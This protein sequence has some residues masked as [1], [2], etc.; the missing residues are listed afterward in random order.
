MNKQRREAAEA[1][2]G[3]IDTLK[4]DE[5]EGIVAA[6]DSL[7]EEEQEGF[8]NLPENFQQGDRGQAMEAAIE[9]LQEA[10]DAVE[11]A[12]DTLQEA[13]DA[14]DEVVSG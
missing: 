4:G 5:M 11:R 1:L 6:I 10:Q 2:K 9:K 12:M 8:D 3:R 14:L 7:R 13:M